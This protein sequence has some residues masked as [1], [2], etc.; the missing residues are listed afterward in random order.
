MRFQ[1]RQCVV[2]NDP[3]RRY[4]FRGYVFLWVWNWKDADR[5]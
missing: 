5:I 2:E 4:F 1:E 3:I